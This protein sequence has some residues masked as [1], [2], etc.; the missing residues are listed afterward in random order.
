M[1]EGAEPVSNVVPHGEVA[2]AILALLGKAKAAV[3]RIERDEAH[4]GGL[5]G[6]DTLKIIGELR[7]EVARWRVV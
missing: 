5:L 2:Q 3:D 7:L 6:R 1:S 4:E